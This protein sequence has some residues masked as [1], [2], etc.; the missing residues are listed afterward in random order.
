ME[1]LKCR[2]ASSAAAT[3]HRAQNA[4]ENLTADLR[5]D[6]AGGA[7]GERPEDI[8]G[9]VHN[10][11]SLRLRFLMALRLLLR[12]GWGLLAAL[13]Q[14]FV[15]RFP[16]GGVFIMPRNDRGLDHAAALV[17]RDRAELALGR[18]DERSAR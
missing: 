15:G 6:R 18:R 1:N 17:R 8:S 3:E 4:A 9:R 11:R 14:P 16:V 5:S 12:N 10:R 7:F 13:F 2:L